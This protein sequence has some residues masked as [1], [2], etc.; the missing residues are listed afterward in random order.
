MSRQISCS[1]EL[2]IINLR[3]R[4]LSSFKDAPYEIWFQM[5]KMVTL[6]YYLNKSS[7]ELNMSGLDL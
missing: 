4:F 2:I 1:V 7:E 3:A 6:G 5:V